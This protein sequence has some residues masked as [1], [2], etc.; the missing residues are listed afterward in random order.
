MGLWEAGL[1]PELQVGQ[2]KDPMLMAWLHRASPQ[3]ELW[4]EWLALQTRLWWE[5]LL[6]RLWWMSGLGTTPV[7]L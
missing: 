5:G 4:S 7:Q 6:C 2:P 3:T 1:S